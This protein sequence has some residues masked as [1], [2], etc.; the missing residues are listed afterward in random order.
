MDLENLL[1]GRT[2]IL[3]M[4]PELK[5]LYLKYN[6]EVIKEY[7]SLN[8]NDN[9]ILCKKLDNTEEVIKYCDDLE[10]ISAPIREDN[11]KTK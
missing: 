5:A 4:T 8:R 6:G 7:C 10:N 2:N 9:D 1:Y 3:Q 11:N